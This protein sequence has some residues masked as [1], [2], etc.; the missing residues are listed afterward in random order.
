[1]GVR[2]WGRTKAEAFEEAGR[3]LTAVMTD[4]AQVRGRS[5][6]TLQCQAVDDERLL[7]AWLNRLVTEMSLRGMLFS[8]FRVALQGCE[9]RARVVGERISQPRHHPAVE[10]RRATAT[11]LR[12]LQRAD[13][14]WIAQTVVDV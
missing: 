5:S 3:A 9:L 13:G 11:E 1:M 8:G 6:I 12:V 7:L 4:P 2:G 14:L 10:I